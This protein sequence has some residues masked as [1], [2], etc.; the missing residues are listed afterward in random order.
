[1]KSVTLRRNCT[2]WF[3]AIADTASTTKTHSDYTA[4]GF[5]AVTPVHELILCDL[6]HGKFE[7]PDIVPAILPRY[8]MWNC[9]FLGVEAKASGFGVI[10]EARRQSLSVKEL[11]PRTVGAD[12]RPLKFEPDKYVRSFEAQVRYE[13]GQVYHLRDAPW[14]ATFEAEMLSFSADGA[15]A[16]DEIVLSVLIR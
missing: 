1:M 11:T 3:F 16:Y 7:E 13:A 14:L 12:E 4:I 2:S 15:H 8:R 5:F 6:I 10:Q 9:V